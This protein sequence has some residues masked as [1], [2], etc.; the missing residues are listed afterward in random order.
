[1]ISFHSQL[2]PN[3]NSLKF[4]TEAGPFL[5]TGM[6]ACSSAAQAEAH[7]LS[8]ALFAIPGVVN[9]FALPHFLTVTKA[10]EASWPDLLPRLEAALADY[11]AQAS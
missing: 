11:F 2:T 7:P 3:P 5:E 10:P 6:L 4:I 9:V 8:K 1:M